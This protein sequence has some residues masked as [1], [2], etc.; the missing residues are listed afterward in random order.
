[1]WCTTYFDTLNHLV[2]DQQC[3]RQMDGRLTKRSKSQPVK[4]TVMT[5][6]F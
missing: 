6:I 2:V 5:V 3:D 1:V 4:S